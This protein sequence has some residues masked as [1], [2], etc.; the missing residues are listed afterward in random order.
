MFCIFLDYLDPVQY[1]IEEINVD[2]KIYDLASVILKIEQSI[3]PK[4]LRRPLGKLM[5]IFDIIIYALF[6]Y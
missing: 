6:V 2:K 4:F 5:Q 1:I 3:D